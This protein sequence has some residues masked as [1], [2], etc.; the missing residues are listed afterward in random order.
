MKDILSVESVTKQFNGLLAVDSVSLNVPSGSIYALIGPNGSGKT[1]LANCI[2][3][4]LKPDAGRVLIGGID[5]QKQSVKAKHL[6]AYVSDNPA[7]Y[8][9]LTGVEFM[10]LSAKLHGL[11]SKDTDR[12]IEE[13]KDLFPISD[14]LSTTT[15]SYSRGNIEKTAFLSALLARPSLLVI[16]EPIVGLDPAS[17]KIFGETLKK[18]VKDGGSVLLST[19]TLAFAKKYAHK[20]GI[21][22]K[23]KLVKEI[24]INPKTDLEDLYEQT[25]S[26]A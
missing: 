13:L 14:I 3:G 1:T 2:V 20:V 6:F 16:D 12:R 10:K 24:P 25:T 7:I 26:H 8:P 17:I 23:G 22:Q 11:N 19:H 18:F 4:L 15:D 5:I 9:Y 21:M